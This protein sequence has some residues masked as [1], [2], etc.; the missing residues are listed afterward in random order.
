MGK[1]PAQLSQKQ[2]DVLR[3]ISDGCPSGVYTEGYEHRIVAKALE[4]RGFVAISG[5]GPT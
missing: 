5:H 3:W 4:R 1:N 2:V